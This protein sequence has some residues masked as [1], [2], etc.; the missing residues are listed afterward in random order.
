MIVLDTHVWVWW[1]PWGIPA[2]QFAREI[3]CKTH[4]DQ[5]ESAR[6]RCAEVP[7]SLNLVAWSLPLGLDEWFANALA[8]PGVTLVDLTPGIAH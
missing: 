8:Y 7:S 2:F 3:D 6:F 4:E 5:V 1:C